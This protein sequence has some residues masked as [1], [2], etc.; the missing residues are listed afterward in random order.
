MGNQGDRQ[1]CIMDRDVAK[2]RA[3]AL[4]CDELA[5]RT[6][7]PIARERLLD[8]ARWDAGELAATVQGRLPSR[9]GGSS[10]SHHRGDGRGAVRGRILSWCCRI[11]LS[12]EG[13]LGPYGSRRDSSGTLGL[14]LLSRVYTRAPVR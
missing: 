6:L 7:D 5:K 4:E 12:A 10:W 9:R 3:K 13:G 2:Y 8:T 14:A 11:A 1:R